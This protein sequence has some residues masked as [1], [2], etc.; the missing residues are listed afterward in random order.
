MPS[1]RTSVLSR[2]AIASTLTIAAAFATTTASTARANE[3]TLQNDSITDGSLVG[4]CPCFVAGEE[5]ASWFTSP[6]DGDIVAIQIFW[7][8]TTG[9]ALPRIEEAIVI[10]SAGN[11][12]V[13][14]PIKDFLDTPALQDG[15]LNEFRFRDENMTIPIQIPVQANEEFVVSLVYFNSD[16]ADPAAPGI[17][18]DTNGCQPNTNA[19]FAAGLGWVNACT[20]GVTGDWAIRVIIDCPQLAVPGA[21]CFGGGGCLLLTEDD[22]NTAGGTFAGPGTECPTDCTCDGDANGDSVV[23]VNDITYI[24]SRLGNNGADGDANGDSV[25]DVNDITYVVGRLGNTC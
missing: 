16:A 1:P 19:V 3:I 17:G 23:D 7:G 11:F 22:C 4:L 13:P 24:V 6:C 18:Y 25:I 15:G 21:C 10:Y 2:A 9:G 20:L 12:P 8:S 14:G 5:A